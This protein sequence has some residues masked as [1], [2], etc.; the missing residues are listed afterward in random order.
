LI[1]RQTIL[2]LASTYP[3][4]A[5]DTEPAFVHE[6]AKRLVGHFEVH[7]LCPHAPEAARSEQLDGVTVHRYR[8]APQG[9]QTLVNEGGV[10]AN[11]KAAPLRWL[12][13]PGFLLSQFLEVCRLILSLRP[14]AI[15][16]H[17]ILP[18]G[19]LAWLAMRLTAHRCALL[20]TSHGIDLFGLRGKVARWLKRIVLRSADAITV[21]SSAMV[22]EVLKLGGNANKVSVSPMGVDFA[23]RFQRPAVPRQRNRLLFVGRLVEKKGLAHLLAAMP[24]VLARHPGV[25]LDV[26]GTGPLLGQSKEQVCRL[27]LEDSVSFKGALPN[28]ELPSLYASATVF[29]APFVVA[30]SGDQEGLGLVVAEALAC[31]C[32]VIVG[33]V[34]ATRDFSIPLIQKVTPDSIAEAVDWILQQPE[35]ERARLVRDQFQTISNHLDW[36]VVAERYRRLIGDLVRGDKVT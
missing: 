35:A 17:W 28:A 1:E 6:L 26:V 34:P 29:V 9:W 22:A 8:Y 30:G 20:V 31:G 15:H 16:A 10:L 11:L 33:D 24:R 7:V 25:Q 2:V 27:G 5:N 36:R 12:L 4:W 18:Q 3:R 14:A 13:V 32:P 19:L 21:V 23:G